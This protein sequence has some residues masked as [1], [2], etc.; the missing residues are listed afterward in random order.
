MNNLSA[1]DLRIGNW[2][3]TPHAEKENTIVRCCVTA[4]SIPRIANGSIKAD[5]IPLSPSILSKA[6][7]VHDT[8]DELFI[9]KDTA[10]CCYWDGV[11]FI[12]KYGLDSD[13]GIAAC[14]FLHQLQN[15]IKALTGT[16]LEINL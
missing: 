2:V 9:Y 16:E 13:L 10:I 1:Q 7:F 11:E 5:G 15:L 8:D 14:E 4:L 3:A 6:G 12:F